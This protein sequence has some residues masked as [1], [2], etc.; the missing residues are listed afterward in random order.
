MVRGVKYLTLLTAT[1][2]Y[3]FK[4][5]KKADRKFCGDRKVY[6][7]LHLSKTETVIMDT[8][9]H[10]LNYVWT[11]SFDWAKSLTEPIN[12]WLKTCC[13]SNIFKIVSNF[14]FI[15]WLI[16]TQIIKTIPW[17]QA[18]NWTVSTRKLLSY[19]MSIHGTASYLLISATY[20]LQNQ[21]VCSIT[22]WVGF[23]EYI[24]Q[25]LDYLHHKRQFP[26]SHHMSRL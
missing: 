11:N 3:V 21:I 14:W 25:E 17:F 23:H 12:I 15:N 18:G 7:L 13:F 10:A 6:F 20:W 1:L 4:L 5:E 22:I 8:L 24:Q 9:N 19:R 26:T 16:K 2:E